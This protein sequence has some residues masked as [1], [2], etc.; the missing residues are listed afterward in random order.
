MS[1]ADGLIVVAQGEARRPQREVFGAPALALVRYADPAAWIMATALAQALA[2]VREVVAAVPDRVG[3]IVTSAVGPVE[4]L[5][6][7]AEAA[8]DNFASPLRYPAANPGSLAGVSCILFGFRGPSLT[9]TLPAPTGVPLGLL[10]AERWLQQAASY[11]VVAACSAC[12]PGRYV[13][14]CLVLAPR[15][16]PPGPVSGDLASEVNWLSTVPAEA[17]PE[18]P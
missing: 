7:V 17:T 14:R 18:G 2:P 15:G 12:A 11:M 9:L 3:V 13:A 1:L 8:R 5:A 6:T 10:L 4:T 16:S